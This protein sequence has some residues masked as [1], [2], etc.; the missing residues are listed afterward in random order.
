MRLCA[1]AASRRA[2]AGAAAGAGCV[3]PLALRAGA[4]AGG[5]TSAAGV[6]VRGAAAG[7]ASIAPGAMGTTGPA[8]A[9]G[10]GAFARW[11]ALVGAAARVGCIAYQT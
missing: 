11:R 6:N 5:G 10:G 8:L 2:E 9:I 1:S 4:G 3:A 7:G